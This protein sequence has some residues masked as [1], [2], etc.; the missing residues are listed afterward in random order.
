MCRIVVP[1]EFFYLE[2]CIDR[3]IRIKNLHL[4]A[5]MHTRMY[6]YIS[7]EMKEET[8]WMLDACLDLRHFLSSSNVIHDRS[9]GQSERMNESNGLERSNE[10]RS[11]S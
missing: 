3:S 5:H 6:V 11:T 10:S 1:S 9:V 8:N 4:R 7:N 2:P